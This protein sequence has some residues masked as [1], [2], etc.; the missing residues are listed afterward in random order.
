[1]KA[2][3]PCAGGL[4]G[5]A[6]LGKSQLPGAALHLN[7]TLLL[8]S[9]ACVLFPSVNNIASI[10]RRVCRCQAR[11]PPRS[12]PFHGLRSFLPARIPRSAPDFAAEHARSFSNYPHSRRAP[13]FPIMS[14]SDDDTPLV[15][16]KD[17]GE[18]AQH[19][20]LSPRATAISLS[21]APIVLVKFHSLTSQLPPTSSTSF[22]LNVARSAYLC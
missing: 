21:R 12:P 14:S 15:R 13:A 3:R 16:G 18:C 17:Q 5:E 9:P 20:A 2:E 10:A 7:S 1:M 6:Q 11:V 19:P 22:S 8:L 4:S